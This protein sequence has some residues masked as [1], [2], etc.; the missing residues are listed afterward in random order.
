MFNIYSYINKDK[1]LLMNDAK[2]FVSCFL[3]NARS[4]INK[5]NEKESYVNALKSYSIMITESWAR[6]DISDAELSTDN[7]VIF[8]MI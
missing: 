6:E 2:P 3:V 7:S 4:I 1:P 5:R 8:V